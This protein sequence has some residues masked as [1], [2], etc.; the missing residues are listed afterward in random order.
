MNLESGAIAGS[1]APSTINDVPP[2][3]GVWHE[4]S[5]RI[6]LVV[7]DAHAIDWDG[8]SVGGSSAIS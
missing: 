1:G 2:N 3:G 7:G 4:A 8:D 5:V 6:V